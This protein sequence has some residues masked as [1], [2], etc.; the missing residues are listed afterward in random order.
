MDTTLGITV[1]VPLI[2]MGLLAAPD[3][4]A[5]RRKPIAR[6]GCIHLDDGATID[7][8]SLD[9]LWGVIDPRVAGNLGL[10]GAGKPGSLPLDARKV[11]RYGRLERISVEGWEY[12]DVMGRPGLRYADI[13]ITARGSHRTDVRLSY[14]FNV[15]I[16]RSGAGAGG[17]RE[18][19]VPWAVRTATGYRLH[20]R[21]IEFR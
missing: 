19:Y 9:G 13:A 7:F 2:G 5:A 10:H 1:L 20:I 11:L 17:Q 18:Q 4:L 8:E 3:V 6:P 16:W 12:T 15:R 21:A 14:L